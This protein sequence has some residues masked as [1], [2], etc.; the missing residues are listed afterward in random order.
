MFYRVLA[1]IFMVI[2]FAWIVFMLL[3]LVLTIRA[4]FRPAFFDR[5]MFR[6]LHL[7]GI[8]FVATLEALRMYCPL[9]L[10]ENALRRHYDPSHEYP[11]SFIIGYL[12]RLI[13]PD[14]SPVV[15][16]IPTVMI[17]LFVLAVFIIKPP[18]KFRRG[19]PPS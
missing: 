19:L 9:T 1:D 4:F 5:W 12:E 8:M 10:W 13:Y 11:G 2:H 17:A 3:G 14:V 16:M 6:T 15:L 7:A 18:A